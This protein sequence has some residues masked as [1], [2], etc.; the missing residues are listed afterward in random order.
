M[1]IQ[2]GNSSYEI[3]NAERV[4]L[5]ECLIV[6]TWKDNELVLNIDETSCF[7]NL[8]ERHNDWECEVI[9]HIAELVADDFFALLEQE[10]QEDR[11]INFEETTRDLLSFY[12]PEERR[13]VEN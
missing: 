11:T 7:I 8:R 13:F 9:D 6:I 10:F 2:I 12:L 1:K 4:V 5:D 3:S